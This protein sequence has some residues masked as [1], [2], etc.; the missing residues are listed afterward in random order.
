MMKGMK[1]A[2]L[3]R[4]ITLKGVGKGEE[5]EGRKK[6]G[7][8]LGIYLK[9][10]QQMYVQRQFHSTEGRHRSEGFLGAIK[11]LWWQPRLGRQGTK[12]VFRVLRAK[13]WCL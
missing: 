3:P 4:E 13:R 7:S 2:T 9:K 8:T 6:T 10:S 12:V 1:A 5:K 11:F